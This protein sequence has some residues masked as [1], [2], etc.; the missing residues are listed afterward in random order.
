MGFVERVSS[1]G[2]EER[3]YLAGGLGGGLWVMGC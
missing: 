1:I 2:A 3:F